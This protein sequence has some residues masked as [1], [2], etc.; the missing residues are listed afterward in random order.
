MLGEYDSSVMSGVTALYTRVLVALIKY[1]D[2][3][4]AVR[5]AS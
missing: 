3:E 1:Q 2:S 4:R 5:T